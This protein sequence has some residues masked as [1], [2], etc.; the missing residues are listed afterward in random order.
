MNKLRIGLKAMVALAIFASIFL[1]APTI[2][3]FTPTHLIIQEVYC[4]SC[5]PEQVSELG[6]SGAHLAHFAS[7]VNSTYTTLTN[8]TTLPQALAIS[9]GCTMCHNYWDNM[10][11]FG[12]NNFSVVQTE[13]TF[14]TA[15]TDIY[16]N[17]VSPYG[18][19]STVAFNFSI[20][21]KKGT[22]SSGLANTGVEPWAAGLGVY[23]YTNDTG[24]VKSRLDYVWSNL[25]SI[26]PGPAFFSSS[27]G[28]QS[29]SCGTA[30]KGLCHIAASSVAESEFG[31][32]PE[33]PN[34][35]DNG[36]NV[37]GGT[38]TITGQ[39]ATHGS[40]VFFRHEMA[41]TTAQYAAKPVKLCGACHV[42]KLPPMSW[43]GEPWSA[44]VITAASNDPTFIVN[45]Q[46]GTL[47]ILDATTL[48]NARSGASNDYGQWVSLSGD[49]FGFTPLYPTVGGVFLTGGTAAKNFTVLYKTP[50]WAHA[51]VPCIR[52]HA[53]AGVNGVSVTNN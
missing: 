22:P 40:G 2:G 26:S 20:G 18:L 24:V 46:N 9:D 35:A 39:G 45:S 38:G 23:Q 42:F 5:H 11:W 19:S 30:E 52:C 44:A 27:G 8:G 41:F 37:N 17:K 43:G 12:V 7:Q 53:H 48:Q 1:V 14:P 49:P 16:G 10:E 28:T 36:T 4:G 31:A 47:P 29:G 25:S 34:Q 13:T 21:G 33:Y 15:V 3:R 32:R 50:D 6:S 51:N